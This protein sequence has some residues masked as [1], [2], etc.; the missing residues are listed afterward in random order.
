MATHTH[1]PRRIPT[2][3]AHLALAGALLPS[4]ACMLWQREPDYYSEVLTELFESRTEA[5]DACYDRYL[6]EVDEQAA[7]TL[8]V[9]SSS[10]SA[11]NSKGI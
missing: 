6:T 7:G 5:I 9:R 10:A 2:R 8:V 3:L 4:L 11:I 1:T